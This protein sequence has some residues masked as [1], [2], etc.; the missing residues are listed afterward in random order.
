[1][2]DY[3]ELPAGMSMTEEQ[4]SMPLRDAV[5]VTLRK[6]ILT[7]RLKPDERLTEIKLGKLLGTSRTPI[8]E[9]IRK[10]ELE[11]LVT[12]VPGSGD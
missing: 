3:N 5:F 11:G 7:G 12:I 8:R 6:A 2:G 4:Q 1:M 10:L 9:A